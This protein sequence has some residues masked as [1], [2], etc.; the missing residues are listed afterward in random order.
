MSDAIDTRVRELVKASSPE[1]KEAVLLDLLAEVEAMYAGEPYPP[2]VN[3]AR[4]LRQAL[5][6]TEPE[7]PP[8]ASGAELER[9]R[10]YIRQRLRLTPEDEAELERRGQTL[11][12][13]VSADEVSRRLRTEVPAETA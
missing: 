9:N 5:T 13:V 3:A 12:D 1:T 10:E 8:A 4:G 2:L 6:A 11:D 7:S